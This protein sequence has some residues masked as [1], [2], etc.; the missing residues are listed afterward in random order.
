MSAGAPHWLEK[1]EWSLSWVWP[2]RPAP[3]ALTSLRR[4]KGWSRSG[5]AQLASSCQAS[6]TA[7]SVPASV[8]PQH[9]N[10]KL[11]RA[12]EKHSVKAHLATPQA[13]TRPVI[14]SATARPTSIPLRPSRVSPTST[15]AS[16]S[17]VS[18]WTRLVVSS[19]PGPSVTN[20][21]MS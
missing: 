13:A 18:P 19:S 5:L 16:S 4:T 10:I 7:R 1:A 17:S 3:P 11:W 12:D 9:L 15:T 6:L 8:K 21:G 2:P 14:P 20:S